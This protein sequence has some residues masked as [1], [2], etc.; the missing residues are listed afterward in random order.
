MKKMFKF[1]FIILILPLI[2]YE[3]YYQ[4]Q[5]F[6]K[7][8]DQADKQHSSTNI[9]YVDQG[10]YWNYPSNATFVS[11]NEDG[12]KIIIQAD[13]LGFRNPTVKQDYDIL[14]LGD[15][16]T[17]A[18]NTK[19]ELTF[20]S[21]LNRAG[22]STYN[23]GID[24][25]GTIHQAHILNDILPRVTPKMVVLNFYLGNDFRDNFYCPELNT[26]TTVSSTITSTG[27]PSAKQNVPVPVSVAL[28]ARLNNIMQHSGVLKLFYNALYLPTKYEGSDMSYYNRGELMIMAHTQENGH[29]D[30]LKAILKTK[31][32][33]AYIQKKLAEKNI[34]FV[35]VGIPSKA[36]T[37]QSVREIANYDTDKKAGE[38]FAKIRPNLDFNRPDKILA[39]LCEEQKIPYISLLQPF[40]QQH[41][42]K[43]FYHFDSHWTYLGQEA[44]A[45]IVL[46]KIREFFK[47]PVTPTLFAP[48]DNNLD[49]MMG[50]DLPTKLGEV[51]Q[52]SV[53]DNLRQEST[54]DLTVKE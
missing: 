41:D 38:F 36:Q 6:K 33:L 42:K 45:N 31:T 21:H 43:L 18:A 17:S 44:A 5:Q 27:I 8:H 46:P 40:R 37:I 23:A 3:G 20:A 4:Y 1:I 53:T 13:A 51:T 49:Q 7:N 30:T 50:E 19:E 14:L 22:Y 11:H 28:K 35:V 34:I 9:S 24:G 47:T 29:P 39:A 26:T 48:L 15:S 54:M 10:Y 25:T 2:L 32:A 12:E 52:T 16:F